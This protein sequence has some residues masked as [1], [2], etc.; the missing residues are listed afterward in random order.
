MNSA[1]G[2]KYSRKSVLSIVL[3]VCMLISN[4]FAATS[5]FGLAGAINLG[6]A[7]EYT[8][9]GE[10]VN[11]GTQLDVTITSNNDAYML[12]ASIFHLTYNSEAL[13]PIESSFDIGDVWKYEDSVIDMSVITKH[14]LHEWADNSVYLSFMSNSEN[15]LCRSGVV[16]KLSFEIID[17]YADFGM[18]YVL[19]GEKSDFYDGEEQ[20]HLA[21]DEETFDFICVPYEVIY[22][23]PEIKI[24]EDTYPPVEP[25]ETKPV[26]PE[27]TTDL[28][29][30]TEPEE[31][32]AKP[33]DTTVVPGTTIPETT[34]PE[35]IV[36]D[37]PDPV[38]YYLNGEVSEDGKRLDVTID[39]E[40]NVNGL[41][42]AVFMLSYDTSVLAPI[43]DSFENGKVWSYRYATIEMSQIEEDHKCEWAR[44]YIYLSF[45]GND[46]GVNGTI[47]DSGTVA[48]LSFDILAEGRDG[49]GMD[50][51]LWSSSEEYKGEPTNHGYIDQNGEFKTIGFV[52]VNSIPSVNPPV[53]TAPPETAVPETTKPVEPETTEPEE[54]TAEPEDTQPEADSPVKY[55]VNGVLSEDGKTLDVVINVEN[56][57]KGLWCALFCLDYDETALKPIKDSFMN[58][59]VW[60]YQYANIDISTVPAD[61]ANEW[62]QNT[63]YIGCTGNNTD[64]NGTVAESGTFVKLSFEVIGESDDL[65][66]ELKLWSTTPEYTEEATN[67]G[68]LDK[69]GSFV[70]IGYEVSYDLP[71]YVKPAETT[72]PEDTKE[73]ED[74]TAPED[75]KEPEDTT[76]P[77]DT[78]EPEDT[79]APEDTKEPE[80]TDPV[81]DPEKAVH[82]NIK[83]KLAEG[84]TRLDVTI[85][86]DNN[87]GLWGAVMFLDY[88]EAALKPIEDALFDANGNVWSYGSATIDISLMTDHMNEWAR[89]VVYLA[90][91]GTSTDKNAATAK[92]GT[93]AT[94]SFEILDPTLEHGIEFKPWCTNSEY[95]FEEDSHIGFDENGD[96]VHKPFLVNYDIKLACDEH[97]EVVIPAVGVTCTS[98]GSTEGIKCEVCDKVLVAPKTILAVGHVEVID[99]AKAPTC[100]ETGLT[101]GS[102]CQ[103]CGEVIVSQ[104]TVDAL[105]H[106]II[107]NDAKAPTCLEIGWAEYETCSRCDNT[108]YA[109]LEAL[110][111]DITELDAL[112]HTEVVLEAVAPTCTATGLTAGMMCSACGETLVAQEVVDEL[113]HTE[114]VLEAIAPTC[115]ETG[116]TAGVKCSVCDEVLEAQEEVEALGHTEG[117]WI[118]E[119]EPTEETT[120]LK[121]VPCTVCGERLEEEIIP[122]IEVFFDLTVN[123]EVTKHKAGEV[124]TITA[125]RMEYVTAELKAYVFDYWSAEGIELDNI[126]DLEITFV[127]PENDVEITAE[128]FVHGNVDRDKGNKVIALDILAF[129]KGIKSGKTDSAF[130]IN[131]D[132]KVTSLDKL[133]LYKVIKGVFDYS[134][135][136]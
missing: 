25:E 115:T 129:L 121:Y 15:G 94:I 55:S 125:K 50:L 68:Y 14:E 12:W 46:P 120:G 7:I 106:D 93:V 77:E 109:E 13:K 8:V 65:G 78:K 44:N 27:E 21:L 92:S 124:I 26:E 54:T 126:Y 48:K 66:I 64:V 30:E 6:D 72:A 9:T 136:M 24:P 19:W 89:N 130:D 2:S 117:E 99:A 42:C 29:E 67:H 35:I 87:S 28:P 20:N 73:P 63:V 101:E 5:V 83:S 119:I 3:V 82:Y 49:L 10:L 132:G 104:K 18:E 36:P 85:E 95:I 31:T 17:P 84:G 123:G 32:T 59:D 96:M 112:G 128:K 1:N 53:E 45:T 34:A 107:N 133:A 86:M 131:L 113:G 39:I 135:Y 58:G 74:T 103:T 47:A 122:V 11:N 51:R 33:E 62:A 88:N 40:N 110:G 91:T 4:V 76:A 134:K 41:W 56:N 98:N 90:F 71:E 37:N 52:D 75:T 23:L 116:L 22:D 108:T 97:V 118:T 114:V 43:V 100:V 81:I 80:D 38:Y 127:M 57:I 61:H 69:D 105:G 16:A 111:H 102:H 79:T 60:S 70:T